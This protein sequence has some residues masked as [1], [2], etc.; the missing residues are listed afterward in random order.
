MIQASDLIGGRYRLENRIAADGAGEAWQAQDLVQRRPVVVRLLPA[1]QAEYGPMQERF[2]AEAHLARSVSH[3]SIAQVFDY[4]E[5]GAGESPYLVTELVDAPSLAGLLAAGPLDPARTMDVLTQAAAGLQAAHTAGLVHGGITPARLLLEPAGQ[6]KITDFAVACWA[7]EAPGSSPY[8]DPERAA[9]GPASPASDLYSLGVTACECL[10]GTPAFGRAVA[11]AGA[12]RHGR[13]LPP[14][15]RTVP[16]AVTG[17]IDELIAWDPAQ[18]PAS[19]ERVSVRARLLHD[20]LAAGTARRKAHA[21]PES[22]HP[23]L[24]DGNTAI[25]PALLQAS[26]AAPPARRRPRRRLLL[27]GAGAAVAIGLACWLAV[28][29]IAGP[30]R[31]SQPAQ[32]AGA[33]PAPSST[34]A[35][36]H[37]AGTVEVSDA[38]QAGQ[39]V[40]EVSRRLRLAGLRPRIVWA[41]DALQAPDTVITVQPVGR[42]PVGSVVTLTAALRPAT[43]HRSGTG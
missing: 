9:D 25:I 43:H 4:G 28:S 38:A 34:R 22:R 30:L 3:P 5:G 13:S 17:L 36:A 10:T 15:P 35:G 14:L 1:D 31:R 7:P 27:A 40:S 6:V 2:H 33:S 21:A 12:T 42:V 39:P 24:V 29:V 20:S 23:T 11:K 26:P 8:L 37:S 41:I 19:A 32:G 16:A 18:R